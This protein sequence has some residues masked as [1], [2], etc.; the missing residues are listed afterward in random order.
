MGNFV[1]CLICKKPSDQDPEDFLQSKKKMKSDAHINQEII[2]N[3]ENELSESKDSEN[4]QI[5]NPPPDVLDKKVSIDDFSILRV[6]GRGSF[7]KVLLVE[8]KD[9]SKFFIF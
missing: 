2:R 9:T 8:K 4:I 1:N 6:L 3:L 5:E 7:G